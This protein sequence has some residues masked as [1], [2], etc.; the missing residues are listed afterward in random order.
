MA[1]GMRLSSS[2]ILMWYIMEKDDADKS[3]REMALV[4]VVYNCSLSATSEASPAKISRTR[5]DKSR[6]MP[7]RLI[8][9][10]NTLRSNIDRVI[11]TS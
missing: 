5:E 7:Q 8:K 1:M 9:S 2:M 10:G 11:L 3:A 6:R 4:G